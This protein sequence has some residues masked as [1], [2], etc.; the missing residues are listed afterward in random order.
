MPHMMRINDTA[1]FA[2]SFVLQKE[3]HGPEKTQGDGLRAF[4]LSR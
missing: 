1:V 2:G 3:Q 4:L